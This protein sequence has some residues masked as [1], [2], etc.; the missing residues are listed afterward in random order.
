MV[1]VIMLTA[2]AE[3][4]NVGAARDAGMTEFVA[5]PFTV[6]R[7]VERIVQWLIT[8]VVLLWL[9]HL[10]AMTQT[11][12]KPGPGLTENVKD[13]STHDDKAQSLLPMKATLP[14]SAG[15]SLKRPLQSGIRKM[16]DETVV[17]GAQKNVDKQKDNFLIWITEDMLN[18]SGLY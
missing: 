9:I 7:L 4:E 18:R 1:P 11:P 3:V 13:G 16:L 8:H 5:K 10:K 12:R 6:K 2:R 14:S 15:L 17:N